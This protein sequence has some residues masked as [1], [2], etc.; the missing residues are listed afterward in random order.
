MVSTQLSR[1]RSRWF[2]SC[3]TKSLSRSPRKSTI[4]SRWRSTCWK[5][6]KNRWPMS[7]S[8]KIR[9]KRTSSQIIFHL[10]TRIHRP[11][12]RR[13]WFLSAN[14]RTAKMWKNVLLSSKLNKNKRSWNKRRMK[15]KRC[16]RNPSLKRWLK[17]RWNHKKVGVTMIPRTRRVP[18]RMSHRLKINK[19]LVMTKSNLNLSQAAN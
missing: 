3:K 1:S 12:S 9:A 19:W 8:T 15:P 16:K 6:S 2:Q 13:N 5:S 11:C 17:L 7:F 4:C 14:F 18:I 10:C